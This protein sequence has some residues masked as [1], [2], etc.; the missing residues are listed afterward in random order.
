MDDDAADVCD[1]LARFSRRSLIG[2][3]LSAAALAA[4]P[5]APAHGGTGTE[6]IPADP[7]VR[8]AIV[9]RMRYRADAGMIFWW[10]RGTTYAQQGARLTPL[11]GLL[12]GSMIRL[13]PAADGG[14]DVVQYELGFRTDLVTGERIETLKNPITGES[15]AIPT[16]PVGP[17]RLHYGPDN[18]PIVPGALGG[19]TLRYA[20]RPERF[21]RSGDT[22]FMQYLSESVVETAGKPDRVIN[23][24]GTIYAP[25]REALDPKVKSARAWVQ[26][27]D[28]TDYARWLNM[29]AGSGSQTLRSIGAKVHRYEDLPADWIEMVRRFD[30]EMAK[31]PMSVFTRSQATYKG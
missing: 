22:V 20:H 13:T 31:D 19:S 17:S 16:Y 21:W 9:R 11:C 25:A 3:G 6:G 29:P 8:N 18:T 14:F 2:A 23:D 15:L 7:A 28:V 12:F 26:S 1:E 27:S 30:P 10:F 24:F 5:A 4:L